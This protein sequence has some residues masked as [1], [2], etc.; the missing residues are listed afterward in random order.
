[1]TNGDTRCL[2]H[3]TPCSLSL[4]ESL[5]LGHNAVHVGHRFHVQRLNC[6]GKHLQR[7]ELSVRGSGGTEGGAGM[8]GL[9]VVMA[10][11]AVYI[12]FDSIRVSTGHAGVITGCWARAKVDSSKQRRWESSSSRFFAGV[13]SLFVDARRKWAWILTYAGIALL[14]IEVLSRVRFMIDTK[15]THFLVMLVLFAAGCAFMFRSYRDKSR[16]A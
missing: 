15:L 13:F 11:A 8:F 4:E 9:G 14:A 3:S 16:K 6:Y 5:R 12:F 2:V 10:V 7:K 1:M